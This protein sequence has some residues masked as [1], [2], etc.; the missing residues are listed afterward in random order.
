MAIKIEEVENN[1]I[2]K[3]KYGFIIKDYSTA[4][5]ILNSKYW[6]QAGLEWELFFD[7]KNAKKITSYLKSMFIFLDG[8]DHSRLRKI[9]LPFFTKEKI[10]EYLFLSDKIFKNLLQDSTSNYCFD[11][12][13][14]VS[15]KYFSQLITE[16][17]GIPPKY[18][19]EL[20]RLSEIC[21]S[22]IGLDFSIPFQKIIKDFQEVD[23]ILNK[24]IKEKNKDL[25]QDIIS[26][27]CKS[28]DVSNDEIKKI[29]FLLLVA[30]YITTSAQLSFVFYRILS[31]ENTYKLLKNN[32]NLVEKFVE[33][34]FF[35]Y[36]SVRNIAKKSSQDITIDGFL[37]K[38]NTLI[39]IDIEAINKKQFLEKKM[40]ITKHAS[41]GFGPHLCIGMLIAKSQIAAVTK[42]ILSSTENLKI[43]GDVVFSKKSPVFNDIELMPVSCDKISMESK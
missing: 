35:V 23:S 14:D 30:G 9:T 24:I 25:K 12:N 11:F 1:N 32:I 29:I 5:K 33:E 22:V 28:N 13:K 10:S 26:S 40:D 8:K 2:I 42:K 3:T 36:T 4:K 43:N 38:K 15:K 16:I 18:S 41:F 6:H 39:L 34:T 27:L 19:G 20:V 17:L 31:D 7:D 21:V 37:F